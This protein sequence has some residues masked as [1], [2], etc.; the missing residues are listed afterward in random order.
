MPEAPLAG[1]TKIIKQKTCA[2]LRIVQCEDMTLITQ[3]RVVFNGGS[4]CWYASQSEALDSRWMKEDGARIDTREYVQESLSEHLAMKRQGAKV[5]R[6]SR[7]EIAAM[8]RD[9]MKRGVAFA[10]QP[11]GGCNYKVMEIA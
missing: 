2:R 1:T 5:V 11:I 9:A 7:H 4:T 3:F 6:C 8:A 10:A